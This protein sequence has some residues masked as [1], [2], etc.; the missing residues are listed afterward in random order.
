MCGIVGIVGSLPVADRLL[1]GLR[2]L[3]YRGYDS[4]GIATVDGKAIK[5]LRAEGKLA[6]L[7][8]LLAQSPLPGHTGIGHTRW[9]THGL[10]TQENAHP[11][12]TP[13]VA[14]VHNGII[15]N[16]SEL[17]KELQAQGVVFASQTDTEVILHLID[18][19]LLKGAT[20]DV[21]V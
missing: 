18:R 12:A 8:R 7:E 5:R 11:H 16:F 1:K 17:K 3:E 14:L 20:P 2:K 4:S 9:A 15:E 6:N 21:A 19:E 10:P 13:R